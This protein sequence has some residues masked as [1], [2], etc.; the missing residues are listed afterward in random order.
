MNKALTKLQEAWEDNPLAVI[1][2]ASVAAT[3]TAK[4]LEASTSRVNA[5]AWAKEVDRRAMI[6]STR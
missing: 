6:A 3:A 4:L 2:V 1:V 5:R